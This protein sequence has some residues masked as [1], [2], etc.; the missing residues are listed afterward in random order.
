MTMLVGI[1]LASELTSEDRVSAAIKN[2]D[3]KLT[4]MYR[5]AGIK[6]S[7]PLLY[8]RAFKREA[9]LEVWA[10]DK[11]GDKFKLL[12]TYAVAAQSG[13]LGPKRKEGDRQVPEGFYVIDRFNPQSR[14]HLSLG[15][16]YP[17]AS[18]RIL[19]DKQR[20]GGDIFIHGDRKSIGCLAMTDPIIE[21]IY[22][23][24]LRARQGGQRQIRVDIFPFRMTVATT[25][26]MSTTSPNLAEFW[27]PLALAYQGFEKSR[28]VPKFKVLKSGAY[29]VSSVRGS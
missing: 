1:V 17:N 23:L 10:S 22:V 18:D 19:S 8:I 5:S 9:A 7:S 28:L 21:E 6:S 29:E 27:K 24:A 26:A 16:N 3:R 12:A 15:I 14:F 4:T 2:V 13:V 25:R 20:P 11:A